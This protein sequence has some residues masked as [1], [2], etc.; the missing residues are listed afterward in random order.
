MVGT[1][2]TALE[3]FPVICKLQMSLDRVVNNY[4]AENLLLGEGSS[5]NACMWTSTSLCCLS[6]LSL[7]NVTI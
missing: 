2:M 4:K 7:S 5:N 3:L 1:S 6:Y